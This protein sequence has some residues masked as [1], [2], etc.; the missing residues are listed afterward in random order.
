MALFE[1]LD[2]LK[3]FIFRIVDNGGQTA[4]R[5]TVITCDGD[6]Y[7]MSSTPFH[8]QGVGMTGEGIDVQGVADRVEAGVERD[9]RWIDL[10]ADCQRC[11]MGGL[12]QGFADY[13]E[14]EP[15]AASRD[16]ALNFQGWSDW[17]YTSRRNAEK[18]NGRL[19]VIYRDG[20]KFKVRCDDLNPPYG[21][22]GD[23][24]FDSFRE[25]LLY[26]LPA[27][28][29][30][31]GPE[32]H[33]EIDIWDTE[34]GP[35]PPWDRDAE[36]PVIDEDSEYARAVIVLENDDR[37]LTRVAWFHTK[38]DAENYLGTSATIDPDKLEAGRYTIDDL[39]DPDAE[40]D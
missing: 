14:S 28:Y 6:Y 11:V 38:T 27:D 25:A 9:L 35:V 10:P 24:E 36:P 22:D 1:S 8:P 16:E 4:D 30:L 5:Y 18:G 21:D 33:T 39:D 37:T 3:P 2:D 20:D 7:A 26:C 15:F 32:Y 29:D 34:G 17:E 19:E 13:I 40:E 31:S 23:P 12:N